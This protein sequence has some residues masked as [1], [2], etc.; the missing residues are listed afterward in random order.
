MTFSF[1]CWVEMESVDQEVASQDQ[2]LNEKQR[3]E[4][5]LHYCPAF[6]LVYYAVLWGHGV[7][8]L[9]QYVLLAYVRRTLVADA[10][11]ISLCENDTD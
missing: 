6:P 5:R 4:M 11:P 10:V 1:H 2:L 7:A 9:K 8:M 3:L